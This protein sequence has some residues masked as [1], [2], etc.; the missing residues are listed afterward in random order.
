M[1]DRLDVVLDDGTVIDV[2]IEREETRTWHKM[3]KD[4]PDPRENI[5]EFI[6]T[7]INQNP[8]KNIH[9]RERL[10]KMFNRMMLPF[11]RGH[12]PTG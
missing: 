7:H 8:R 9:W 5:M 3:P 12:S 2:F 4:L 1:F 11:R 6:A 10:D